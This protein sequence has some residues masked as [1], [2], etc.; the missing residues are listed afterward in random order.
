MLV[1]LLTKYYR[2][3]D[4]HT[5]ER[6]IAARRYFLWGRERFDDNGQISTRWRWQK[7]IPNVFLH[8]W[9]NC[10]AHQLHTHPN[11]TLS[12]VLRGPILEHRVDSNGKYSIKELHAGAI[13]FRRYDE[14]HRYEIPDDVR[15]RGGAWTVF[16]RGKWKYRQYYIARHRRDE[17]GNYKIIDQHDFIEGAKQ[18]TPFTTGK[19]A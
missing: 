11:W 13:V 18:W 12:L 5:A 16:I 3:V 7:L 4:L 14:F 8:N 9:H 15:K 19:R 2:Y 6:E 17:D 1:R 10:E